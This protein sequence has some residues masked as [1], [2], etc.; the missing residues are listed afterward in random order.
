MAIDKTNIQ[1]IHDA[2]Y[3]DL[4][5]R[6]FRKYNARKDEFNITDDDYDKV[7]NE[8]G[9][10]RIPHN[11]D[12][13]ANV[14]SIS[15]NGSA[16]D[17]DDY[18]NVIDNYLWTLI[19]SD[20]GEGGNIDNIADTL[21]NTVSFTVANPHENGPVSYTWEL[22]VDSSHPVKIDDDG[23]ADDLNDSNNYNTCGEWESEMHMHSDTDEITVLIDEEPNAD[24]VASSALGL[25]R[26]GDG[27]SV[28]TSNDY[29]ESDFND[30]DGNPALGGDEDGGGDHVWYEP[31]DNNGEE[32]PADLWFSADESTDA[33]NKCTYEGQENCDHQTYQWFATMA[34]SVGFDWEDVDGVVDKVREE[35]DEIVNAKTAQERESEL[36]DVLFSLVNLARWLNVDAEN[37]LRRA[38]IRFQN[39]FA[40]MEYISDQRGLS[41]RDIS[42][43]ER[44][45]LWNQAKLELSD[46]PIL[47][48]GTEP[49]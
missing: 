26:A 36:G 47:E 32:N 11:H 19:G 12:P 21:T 3:T 22:Y 44:E 8:T 9:L 34:Y 14:I 7:T 37:T 27:K 48:D 25:I 6:M 4:Q 10:Y 35:I 49:S 46:L 41:L 5:R 24:P 40:K 1:A 13:D 29:D 28:V 39:R 30:Y 33:D 45:S 38:G 31:H 43:C 17:D 20:E 15:D 23:N 16:S 18:P 42:A 2:L